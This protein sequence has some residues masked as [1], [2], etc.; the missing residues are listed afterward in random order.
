M[1][2]PYELIIYH[3]FDFVKFKAFFILKNC[4]FI[5]IDIY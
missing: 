5:I 4:I 1:L 2:N 3:Y